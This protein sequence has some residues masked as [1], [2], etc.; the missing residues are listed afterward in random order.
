MACTPSYISAMHFCVPGNWRSASVLRSEGVNP[1]MNR[2]MFSNWLSPCS[3]PRMSPSFCCDSGGILKP[4]SFSRARFWRA[5]R[6][7]P[8]AS[9]A[10][11]RGPGR[12]IP[13]PAPGSCAAPW[14]RRCK[15]PCAR[16][17][18][19]VAGPA[20]GEFEVV[21]LDEHQRAFTDLPWRIS[22]HIFQDAAVLV[23]EARP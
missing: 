11:L 3:G 23:G 14:R 17:I 21:R 18:N 13:S 2:M 12:K 9:C 15:V 22:D 4:S 16:K 19:H 1:V 7:R 8:S 5:R 6:W 20:G 10:I